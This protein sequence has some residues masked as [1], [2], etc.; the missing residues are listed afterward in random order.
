MAAKSGSEPNDRT[1]LSLDSDAIKRRAAR[2]DSE[3]G[4]N[5]RWFSLEEQKHR[6][7]KRKRHVI[8]TTHSSRA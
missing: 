7:T 3:E 1:S 5:A 2:E 4:N 8:A 6:F